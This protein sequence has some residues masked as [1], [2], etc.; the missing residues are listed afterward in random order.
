MRRDLRMRRAAATLVCLGMI[1]AP[2][3]QAAVMG[4]KAPAPERKA[5]VYTCPMDP[6]VRSATAGKCPKCGMDLRLATAD[7][8]EPV[9]SVSKI[10]ALSTR[11]DGSI[12]GLKIPDV[13]VVDQD[14]RRLRFF[15]DLVKGRTVAI[16]FMFTTCTTICPPLAATFAK[17]QEQLGAGAGA[18]IQLISVSVDPVT[19]VPPRMKSYLTRFGAR[20]GWTFVGGAKPDIDELLR[21]LGAYTADKNDHTPMILIGNEKAEYW[22]RAFGLAPATRLASLITEARE[23]GVESGRP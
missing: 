23:K 16:N 15:T 10:A 18:D 13:P 22:T 20:A 2:F 8:L 14:G 11:P 17:V 6:E 3:V 19:D 1:L 5:A 9:Q 7:Q 21:A 4:Q 12:A